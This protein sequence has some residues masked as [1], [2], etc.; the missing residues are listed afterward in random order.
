MASQTNI[1]WNDRMTELVEV[2]R[3]HVTHKGGRGPSRVGESKVI[4]YALDTW[5][6][7]ADTTDLEQL[8]EYV[9]S[10]A[11]MIVRSKGEGRCVKNIYFTGEMEQQLKTVNAV[12]KQ[13]VRTL[14]GNRTALVILA[15]E[16]C[17]DELQKVAQ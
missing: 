12:V 1:R 3:P 2:I 10:Y 6:S 7:N 9:R 16:K 13:R 14:D 5:A 8:D 11:E 17:A 15:L 4:A